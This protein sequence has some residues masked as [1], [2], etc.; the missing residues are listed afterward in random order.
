MGVLVV[1]RE[2]SCYMDM[3]VGQNSSVQMGSKH[4]VRSADIS[5]AEARTVVPLVRVKEVCQTDPSISRLRMNSFP[6]P[7]QQS[8]TMSH[9]L[10][11]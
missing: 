6:G 9:G 11:S 4:D 5:S 7:G 2:K 3:Y 8:G 1:S 10:P